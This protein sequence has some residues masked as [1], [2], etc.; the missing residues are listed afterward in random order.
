MR[1]RLM[2]VLIVMVVLALAGVGLLNAAGNGPVDPPNTPGTTSSYTLND[3][4]ARLN[5]GAAGAQS[6]FTE[7]ASG[8]TSGTMHTL[9]EI[10]AAAPA[11]DVANGATAATVANGKTF[12][13]L[14]S[15]QW[16]LRTGTASFGNT[17]QAGVPK[18]GQITS[19]AAGDDGALQKGVAW[20][21]PRFTDHSNGTVTDNLTGLIWV[22]N[23]NC[24]STQTWANAL[25]A[26]NT[27]ASGSCG[28]TDGSAAG[29]WRLPNVREMQSLV[30]YERFSPALPSGYPFSNVQSNIYWTSTTNIGVG[31]TFAWG[32]GL[33]VGF[34]Y[35][36][37]AAALPK[38]EAYYVW[39]VRGGP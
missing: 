31:P 9:N 30:D 32:V 25:T 24:F 23:A 39:P 15:G 29:A 26:A 37:F 28:L 12:W 36:I 10:M 34:V 4:W 35:G 38:T 21:S 7:P 22:K 18:T 14:T 6:T 2:T 11:L 27:L 19:F 20:P 8:P 17:Y 16:G 3:L 33:Q 1:S 13:G 5:A